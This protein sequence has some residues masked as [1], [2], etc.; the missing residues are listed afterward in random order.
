[1]GMPERSPERKPTV[2]LLHGLARKARSLNP[3]KV[4]LEAAGYPV[5]SQSYPSTTQTL[6]VIAQ[7]IV[8]AVQAQVDG[9]VAAV[10]H[11]MGGIVVRHI[12]DRLPWTKI[13]MLAP[14]N[15]GSTVAQ[16]LKHWRLY[17]RLYGPAGQSMGGNPQHWPKAPAVPIGILAGTG[18]AKLN[19]PASWLVKALR[20]LPKEAHDGTVTVAETQGIRHQ[21]FA[22][23]PCGHSWIMRR[24]ETLPL[25]LRFLATGDFEI[26][27]S[28]H[29]A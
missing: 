11:S 18:G 12:G 1:M 10:T 29:P 4:G 8:E 3:I 23:V 15:A 24:P 9:P 21:S 20:I 22:T 16:S 13:V 2:I 19:N 25:I 27:T 17:R 26:D 5:W 28:A 6:R 14:P 7:E